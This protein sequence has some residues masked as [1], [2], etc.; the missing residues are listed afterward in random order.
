MVAQFYRERKKYLSMKKSGAGA[1]FTTKWFGYNSL[2]F[3]RDKNKVRPCREGGFSETA[4]SNN[5]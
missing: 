1:Y 2:L 3:L 4:V 5:N